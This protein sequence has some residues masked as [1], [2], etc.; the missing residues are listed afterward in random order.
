M[1]T[2]ILLF[3]FM[4]ILSFVL[5][6]KVYST[7]CGA[8]YA[9]QITGVGSVDVYPED[10]FC[11]GDELRI[12]IWGGSP[13]PGYPDFNGALIR[14]RLLNSLGTEISTSGWLQCDGSTV[15]CDYTFTINSLPAGHY[16]V[17]VQ[18]VDDYSPEDGE[19]D[20]GNY[21]EL[22]CLDDNQDTYCFNVNPTAT[23]TLDHFDCTTGEYC[24]NTSVNAPDQ[25]ATIN[26]GDSPTDYS[27]DVSPVCHTC[28]PGTYTVTVTVANVPASCTPATAT[29]QI[30]VGAPLSITLDPKNFMDCSSHPDETLT[31][32]IDGGIAN[33]N[34]QWSVPA[35]DATPF[36]ISPLTSSGGNSSPFTFSPANAVTGIYNLVVTD[37][38]GCT[39]SVDF[40][41][42]IIPCCENQDPQNITE[43]ISPDFDNPVDLTSYS[44]T[45]VGVS[46]LL[47]GYFTV[48]GNTT[49]G[50]PCFPHYRTPTC[51]AYA[52]DAGRDTTVCDSLLNLSVGITLGKPAADSVV[53]SWS[54]PNDLSFGGST[55]AQI[56]VHP[57]QTA[58]YI[59]HI[60]DTCTHPT[61][62]C[63]ERW[64][65]VSVEV[66]NN[67]NPT[68]SPLTPEG[69]MK[70]RIQIMPNP[71]HDFVN[72]VVDKSVLGS[73]LK[74]TDVTGRLV[75][76]VQLVTRNTQLE[77][78][79]FEHGMYFISVKNKDGEWK[80][81]LVIE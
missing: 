54:S 69:G 3:S 8:V 38:N 58:T 5:P 23:L 31:A 24:F 41:V 34:Y 76:A 51:A 57:S 26:F 39:A 43:I 73:E 22:G 44:A 81:K 27:L 55:Q 6:Q 2:K 13:T 77:T 80:E 63:T 48:S 40:N 72:V 75:L 56:I 67:C 52:A 62:S 37:G 19:P 32:N 28:A 33:Y 7:D 14:Y 78:S 59:L 46:Y 47:N 15:I 4:A 25:D 29:L 65:T 70:D 64:D 16:C 71:A 18:R 53:Y 49:N 74:I 60:Q 20:N 21:T 12:Y 30:T 66:T 17:V 50:M 42:N 68:A 9:Q 1:K 45:Y 35:A 36:G 61:Y 10:Y 11:N 79:S